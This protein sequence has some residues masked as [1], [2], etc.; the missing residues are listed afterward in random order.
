ML[1]TIIN[2]LIVCWLVGVVL[3]VVCSMQGMHQTALETKQQKLMLKQM[4]E[5][6]DLQKQL[7]GLQAQQASPQQA[8]FNTQAGK[9]SQSSGGQQKQDP[10]EVDFLYDL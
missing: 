4:K 10:A 9:S 3:R 8:N 6:L 7:Q 2:V 5:S 1:L